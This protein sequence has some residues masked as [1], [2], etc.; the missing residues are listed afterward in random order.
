M[1]EEDRNRFA[2]YR[3]GYKEPPQKE[4]DT[5]DLKQSEKVKDTLG[6]VDK[7]VIN[8]DDLIQKVLSEMIQN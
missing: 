4:E 8:Q 1:N 3:P 7:I 6:F 2:R 5:K